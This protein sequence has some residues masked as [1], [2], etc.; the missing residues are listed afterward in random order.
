MRHTAAHRDA[1]TPRTSKLA[2][3][4]RSG[5]EHRLSTRC[6]LRSRWHLLP[7]QT[8][9]RES[10]AQDWNKATAAERRKWTLRVGTVA[11]KHTQ[12]ERGQLTAYAAGCGELPQG[13]ASPSINLVE[14]SALWAVGPT[15]DK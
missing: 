13:P 5:L 10:S 15:V 8:Q 4:K 9:H 7:V 1:C 6:C 14:V 2:T 11:A 12:R 3:V